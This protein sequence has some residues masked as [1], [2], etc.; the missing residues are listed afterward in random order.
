[1]DYLGKGEAFADTLLV[2]IGKQYSKAFGAAHMKTFSIFDF[3][4]WNMQA[5]TRARLDNFVP[6]PQSAH[7]NRR[8]GLAS[9]QHFFSII[10]HR[11]KKKNYNKSLLWN[12]CQSN[13]LDEMC[14]HLDFLARAER[15]SE[16]AAACWKLSAAFTFSR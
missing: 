6:V 16:A 15:A 8:S 2:P 14:R 10:N 5:E 4:S 3:S 7:R 13:R 9:N 1:M 11:E 12:D